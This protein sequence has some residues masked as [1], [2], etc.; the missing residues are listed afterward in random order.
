MEKKEELGLYMARPDSIPD[1][2]HQVLRNLTVAR[3]SHCPGVCMLQAFLVCPGC[4]CCRCLAMCWLLAGPRERAAAAAAIKT[5]AWW[6][7]PAQAVAA[8][9]AAAASGALCCRQPSSRHTG[10]LTALHAKSDIL[11]MPCVNTGPEPGPYVPG[12]TLAEV[13]QAVHEAP[14]LSWQTKGVCAPQPAC[15]TLRSPC[16]WACCCSGPGCSGSC[17]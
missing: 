7:T 16:S 11:W 12:M 8:A 2:N 13:F 6:K 5:L 14:D 4:R 17:A 10:R 1:R 9:K 15:P 3:N